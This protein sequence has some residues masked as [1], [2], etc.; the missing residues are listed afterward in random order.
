M[1]RSYRAARKARA[2]RSENVVLRAGRDKLNTY[3][4]LNQKALVE[5]MISR[6]VS[7]YKQMRKEGVSKQV[8]HRIAMIYASTTKAV[9]G[10]YDK[11]PVQGTRNNIAAMCYDLFMAVNDPEWLE[12]MHNGTTD[13]LAKRRREAKK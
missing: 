9:E 5:A 2:K 12:A 4:N 10:V 1:S 8:S 7:S 6:Y 11:Y 13:E 3:G